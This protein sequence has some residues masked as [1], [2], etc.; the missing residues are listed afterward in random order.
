M[1]PFSIIA[2]SC[3]AFA[4]LLTGCDEG[5][6]YEENKPIAG[7]H[8]KANESVQFEFDVTDTLH[9]HDFYINL[10][11]GEEYPF[12]NLYLFVELEFPNGKKA[13][14]TLNC[15]L[16]DPTGRWLG[17]GLGDIYDNRILYRQRKQFPLTGRYKVGIYQAMRTE[18]LEGI[19]DVGFRVT[20]SKQ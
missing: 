3:I 8:W 2:W 18:D 20:H 1:K 11:N 12:S 7:A 15:P 14:D 9:L 19:Y 17:K 4:A 10:R 5:V 6:V 16:A 13:V